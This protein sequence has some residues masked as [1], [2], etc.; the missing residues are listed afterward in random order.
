MLNQAGLDRP[1]RLQMW[2]ECC[3]LAVQLDNVVKRKGKASSHE[4]YFGK[5]TETGG[6]KKFW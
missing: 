6:Y 2:A 5:N 4:R 3:S 1:F